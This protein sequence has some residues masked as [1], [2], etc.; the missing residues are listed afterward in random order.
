MILAGVVHHKIQAHR[1]APLVALGRQPVQVLHGAQFRLHLAEIA[2]RVPAVAAALGAF[3]QGHEMQIIHAAVGDIIQLFLHAL[4]RSRESLHIHQHAHQIVALV[5]VRV[6]F[7][8]PV[9][10]LQILGPFLP[11]AVQH[12]HKIIVGLHIVMVQLAVQPFQLVLVTAEPGGKF[13]F[14]FRMIHGDIPPVCFFHSEPTGIFT[15]ISV[16][17]IAFAG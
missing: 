13:L 12:A 6:G 3:Q 2:H 11:A 5:P 14:P 17:I 1:D 9:N 10:E 7:P 15:I 4:E 16:S 8:L